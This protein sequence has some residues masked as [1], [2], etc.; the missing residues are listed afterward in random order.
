MHKLAYHADYTVEQTEDMLDMAACPP[1]AM[2]YASVEH[3]CCM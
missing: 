1:E 3:M 2:K